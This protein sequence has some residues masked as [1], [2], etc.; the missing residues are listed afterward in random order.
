MQRA[1]I[2]KQY[3]TKP[4]RSSAIKAWHVLVVLTLGV[5]LFI[6]ERHSGRALLPTILGSA[7]DLTDVFSGDSSAE[8]APV[9]KMEESP[10][11][12]ERRL[13][14]TKEANEK[15]GNGALNGQGEEQGQRG[16][17]EFEGGEGRYPN[18]DQN[19]GQVRPQQQLANLVQKPDQVQAGQEGAGEGGARDD[20]SSAQ[21]GGEGAEEAERTRAFYSSCTIEQVGGRLKDNYGAWSLCGDRLRPGGIVYSFGIGN[22]VSFDHAMVVDKGQQ[23]FGFDPTVTPERVAELFRDN[24]ARAA[25]L[26]GFAF[27]QLGLGAADGSVSFLRSRNPRVQSMTALGAGEITANYKESGFQ[28]AVLRLRT[29]MCMHGHAW[30]DV[31][32]M[33]VEGVEMDVCGGEGGDWAR[34]HLDIPADQVLIEFHERMLRDGIKKKGKCVRTLLAKGFRLVYTSPNK[35]EL[36]FARMAPPLGRR[37]AVAAWAAVNESALQSS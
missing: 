22:D 33:D 14:A 24:H 6:F 21:P 19:Q 4:N 11:R 1:A 26:P 30:V 20:S 17:G 35:Q 29:F 10:M 15:G 34:P 18:E 25:P 36:T 5:Q 2:K 23:V 12:Q 16:R 8:G 28:A 32:K 27:Q 37:W 31:L 3:L 7:R 9:G 13:A